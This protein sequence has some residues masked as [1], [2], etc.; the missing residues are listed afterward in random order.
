M[1]SHDLHNNENHDL[2]QKMYGWIFLHVQF[3]NIYYLTKL[4][5]HNVCILFHVFFLNIHVCH[6]S[7]LKGAEVNGWHACGY[8]VSFL[9]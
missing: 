6:F 9:F 2:K 3:L 7:M 1:F 4:S 8:F 5:K